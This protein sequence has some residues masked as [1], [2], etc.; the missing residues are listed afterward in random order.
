MSGEP[1]TVSTVPGSSGESGPGS[2]DPAAG[3]AWL[4]G[5][6]ED[7]ASVI[8]PRPKALYIIP[9]IPECGAIDVSRFTIAEGDPGFSTGGSPDAVCSECELGIPSGICGVSEDLTTFTEAVIVLPEL[10]DPDTIAVML[11]NAA[12]SVTEG[13]EGGDCAGVAV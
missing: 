2:L 13:T 5:A 8:G 4:E 10:K 1:S 6:G 3:E 12:G 9:P 11:C 7:I